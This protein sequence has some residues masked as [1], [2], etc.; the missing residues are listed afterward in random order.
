MK[1]TQYFIDIGLQGFALAANRRYL[2]LISAIEDDKAGTDNLNKISLTVQ[3][4]D[5]AYRGLPYSS[6]MAALC[7]LTGL[8]AATGVTCSLG[9]KLVEYLAGS[10]F[11]VSMLPLKYAPSSITMRAVLMSPTTLA[12]LRT[13]S[14]S[15]A[16][17]LP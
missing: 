8:A 5:R 7:Q 12:S 13:S 1:K 4:N 3:E 11:T 14:L 17:T 10:G 6:T 16:S 15:L 9:C 2:E